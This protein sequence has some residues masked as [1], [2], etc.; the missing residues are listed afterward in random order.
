LYNKG[1]YRLHVFSGKFAI[2][3]DIYR[4]KTEGWLMLPVNVNFH[5]IIHGLYVVVSPFAGGSRSF[6]SE[7]VEIKFRLQRLYEIGIELTITSNRLS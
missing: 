1:N 2:R 3:E 4:K 6:F 7:V 5:Q